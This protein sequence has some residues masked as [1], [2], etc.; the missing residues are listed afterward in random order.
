MNIS[1]KDIQRGYQSL[2]KIAG[3]ELPARYIKIA[4]RLKRISEAIQPEFKTSR[5][6]L[7]KLLDEY[8]TAVTDESGN[9]T[10]AWQFTPENQMMFNTVAEDFL[11]TQIEIWG[12]PF[13][14]SEIESLGDLIR[15]SVADLM[16]LDWLIVEDS[17]GEKATGATA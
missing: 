16:A 13:L 8:G 17:P 2:S 5:T 15:L 3:V 7:K 4:Y 12:A 9:P 1:L 10:G 14:L 6:H 11:S